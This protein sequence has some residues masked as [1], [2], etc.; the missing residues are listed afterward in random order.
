MDFS[1]LISVCTDGAPSMVG[2]VAGAA[3]LLEKFVDHPILKYHCIIHQEALCGKTLNMQ[4]VMSPVIKCDNKIKVRAL[5]Q[6]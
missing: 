5:N 2:K 3:T 1:K 4:H 6:R